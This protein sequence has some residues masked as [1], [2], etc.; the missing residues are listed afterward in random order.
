MEAP[1]TQRTGVVLTEGTTDTLI[2]LPWCRGICSCLLYLSVF[3]SDHVNHEMRE[4]V[5]EPPPLHTTT[6]YAEFL[7]LLN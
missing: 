2:R 5:M 6:L 7:K 3:A 4:P 1:K